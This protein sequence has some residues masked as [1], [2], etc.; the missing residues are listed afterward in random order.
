MIHFF[1]R[2]R[3]SFFKGNRFTRY[4][5]Y[6]LGEIVL[7]VIGIMIAIQLNEWNAN[8]KL[9]NENYL[10]I[11]KMIGDLK[12]TQSRLDLLLHQNDPVWPSF[13]QAVK[14]ADTLLKLSYAGFSEE[15]I[16]FIG[17]TTAFQGGSM[18]N[19]TDNT[20]QELM[21][22][23]KL[24]T[25]GSDSLVASIVRYYTICER[26]EIYN[27]SN[28]DLLWHGLQ[29]SEKGFGKMKMDYELAT[30]FELSDYPFYFDP[31]SEEYHNYQITLR[32][33]LLGQ[34]INMSKIEMLIRETETLQLQLKHALP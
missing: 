9:Q 34:R 27:I 1:R 23:G 11:R 19:I 17:K 14:N 18:L 33:L 7:V 26:E 16:D 2:Y 29:V 4:L 28:R 6:A 8:R 10:Y 32:Y 24:Y 22:T 21:G 20:Y 3:Q 5:V 12:A 30:N 31:K 25:L 13:K 15:D